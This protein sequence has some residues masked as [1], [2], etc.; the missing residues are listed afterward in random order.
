[1]CNVGQN[2]YKQYYT[3]IE[4][5]TVHVS[6]SGTGRGDQGKRKRRKEKWQI[7]MKYIIAV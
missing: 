4:I 2:K 3:D 6:T 7:I 1:M 5:C